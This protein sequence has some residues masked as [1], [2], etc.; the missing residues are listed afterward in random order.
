V[1]TGTAGVVTLLLA[2]LALPVPTL[3]VA[4]TVNVYVVPGVNPLIL[5]VP[6]PGR[7]DN[8][9]VILPGLLVAVYVVIVAPPLLVGAV[10]ATVAVVCPVAVAV[11]IVG[12]P[13]TVGDT[14]AVAL[15]LADEF[16]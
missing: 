8:V 14:L 10:Y 15:E 16:P 12:A 3:F 4:V 11:P 2:E 13:G 7:P 9:L 1:L 6:L 5:M